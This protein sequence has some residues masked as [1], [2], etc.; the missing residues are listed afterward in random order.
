MSFKMVSLAL[1]AFVVI[2]FGDSQCNYYKRCIAGECQW[3]P[4]NYCIGSG[5]G[6]SQTSIFYSC[7]YFGTQINT[8]RYDASANCT[9]PLSGSGVISNTD[10]FDCNATDC[11]LIV[12]QYDSCT[13]NE[14]TSFQDIAYVTSKCETG[15]NTARENELITCTNTTDYTQTF[16]GSNDVDC[17]GNALRKNTTQYGCN[18]ATNKYI[19][20]LECNSV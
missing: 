20:L 12:R 16:Y 2:A 7:A 15:V 4:P 11:G 17:S 13:I 8:Y 1:L 18:S 9:G 19:K 5:N 10:L 6:N 3:I 14:Q